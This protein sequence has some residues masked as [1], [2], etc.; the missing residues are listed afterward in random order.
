VILEFVNNYVRFGGAAGVLAALGV[1]CLAKET[2]GSNTFFCMLEKA[3]SQV[4]IVSWECAKMS[5]VGVCAEDS[6]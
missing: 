3:L 5:D 1:D 4:L 6:D 2:F